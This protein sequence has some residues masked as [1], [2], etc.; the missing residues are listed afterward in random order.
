MVTKEKTELAG[1]PKTV[2]ALKK[3]A[4]DAEA[5]IPKAQAFAQAAPGRTTA[6]Q[7]KV[8]QLTADYDKLVKQ[9]PPALQPTQT[10]A[11]QPAPPAKG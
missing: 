1:A 9:I 4:S 11:A 2:E 7:Q 5:E 10:A 6:A 3:K 8:D